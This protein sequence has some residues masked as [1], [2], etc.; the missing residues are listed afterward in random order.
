[1]FA[2]KSNMGQHLKLNSSSFHST[3]QNTKK[4]LLF[5][6]LLVEFSIFKLSS[7]KI[8]A[9]CGKEWRKSNKNMRIWDD[10]TF[11]PSQ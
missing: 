10:V 1:M 7:V 11:P 6:I 4:N 2:S 3:L 9:R 5:R 8:Y